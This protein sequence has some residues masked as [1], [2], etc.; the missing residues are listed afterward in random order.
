MSADVGP[1]TAGA[2]G[3][4]EEIAAAPE[5][6]APSSGAEPSEDR[7]S[8]PKRR[9]VAPGRRTRQPTEV[10]RRL[11][12]E[13]AVP[14]VAEKGAGRVGLRD[15]ARAAGVSVGTV[16]YHFGGVQEILTEAVSMEIDGYYRP[17]GERM[18]SR[19][20]AAEGLE[21]LVDGVFNAETD[22]HW[23]LWFDNW[24][25]SADA[26]PDDRQ[27]R[28]YEEWADR[29]A[30]LIRRGCVEGAFACTD[31]AET[32]TRFNALVDGLALRRLRGAP[33]LDTDQARSHLR[34]FLRAELGLEQSPRTSGAR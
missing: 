22:R 29:V 14:L 21:V 32:T 27:R 13:A 18:L 19:P 16:T 11:I 10:R 24:A 2:G 26:A 15:I 30:E 28:R 1:G 4:V 5:A 8:G 34:R 3:D 20:T 7:R 12:L 31:V 9:A 6:P 33:P 25:A 23:R 17:L